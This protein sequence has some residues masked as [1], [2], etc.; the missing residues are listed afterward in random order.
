MRWPQES[1]Y[2]NRRVTVDGISFQSVKEASRWQQLKFL[3]L[4]GKITGLKRQVR[5]EIV[6]KTDLY[7]AAYYVADFVYFD[8]EKG[9]EVYEDVKGYR[10]GLAYEHFK[11]KRKI[12]YER[13]GIMITET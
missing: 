9:V 11:L 4:A 13:Y 6:P 8:K 3:E 5:I 2:H 12:L 1:K 10:A 7:R